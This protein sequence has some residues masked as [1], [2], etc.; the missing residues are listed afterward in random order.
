MG[1]AFAEVFRVSVS[2]KV[3]AGESGKSSLGLDLIEEFRS[4]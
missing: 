2:K 3:T 4:G 1:A